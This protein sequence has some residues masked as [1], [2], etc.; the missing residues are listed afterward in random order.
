MTYFAVV[1]NN[2]VISFITEESQKDFLIQ[3]YTEIEFYEF[4][5]TSESFPMISDFKIENGQL[6]FLE[7][8]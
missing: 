6:S 4:E 8:N 1:V 5:W 3:E 2:T 7:P